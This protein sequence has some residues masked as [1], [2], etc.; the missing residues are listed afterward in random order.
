VYLAEP[1][2]T[3]VGA[4]ATGK[5]NRG[6]VGT[7]VSPDENTAARWAF[8]NRKTQVI[9]DALKDSRVSLRLRKIFGTRALV[10]TPLLANKRALG[11]LVIV[12]SES[13]R[14]FGGDEVTRVET[15][16]NYAAVAIGH[17]AVHADLL[18]REAELR[19]LSERLANAHESERRRISR[20]LHDVVGQ[21]LAALS[22][23]L[24][25]VERH[26]RP[27]TTARRLLRETSDAARRLSAELH[28]GILDDL[29]LVPAVRWY[30]GAIAQRSSLHI[31]FQDSAHP[32]ISPESAVV[33]YRAL[34]EA[35]ANVVRHAHAQHVVVRLKTETRGILLEI[36]DDGVGPRRSSTNRK[37]PGVGLLA[38]RERAAALGGWA[39]F[40]AAGRGSILRVHLPRQPRRR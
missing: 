3:L 11:A 36:E 23:E 39:K 12:D 40:E 5:W 14:D 17:A 38:I 13:T 22:L 19:V 10:A 35:L 31:D 4:A 24:A 8:R 27:I 18:A 20:E 6:F 1:D 2:G 37:G 26:G 32:A 28:P 15:L 21:G 25:A 30:C 29:G 16:A 34:Q 33:L 7:R 9:A